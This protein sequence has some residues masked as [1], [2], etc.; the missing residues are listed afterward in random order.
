MIEAEETRA[1]YEA[2]LKA[3]RDHKAEVDWAYDDGLAKG[4]EEGL[5]K[6]RAAAQEQANE[7]FVRNL[8]AEVLPMD[9]IAPLAELPAE[10]V[11]TLAG[12]QNP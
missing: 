12:K 4:R 10:Q 9:T 2:R 7:R 8:L 1:E 3:R 11:R 6:G 5:T